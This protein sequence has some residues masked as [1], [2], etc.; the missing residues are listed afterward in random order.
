MKIQIASKPTH[1][2]FTLIEMIGVL[3]VIGILAA[4]LVPKIFEAINNAR[5]NSTAV[6]VASIKTGI[7]DHYAKFGS[8]VNSNGITTLTITAPGF[9]NYDAML[10]NE[11]LLDKKLAVKIADPNDTRVVIVAAA[12]AATAVTDVNDAFALG[13]T[14]TVNTAVGS[15]VVEVQ[16]NNVIEADAKALNDLIDGAAL[17]SAT[18]SPD[19]AGRV[20][21]TTPTGSGLVNMKIYVTHR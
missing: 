20:K 7:A 16:L 2:A 3:A 14:T 5:V 6:S 9:T 18:G 1:K 11:G 13:D 15:A 10:L 21:Y 4:L 17:G 8:L 12:T 19:L